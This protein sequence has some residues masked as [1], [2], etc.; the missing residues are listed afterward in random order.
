MASTIRMHTYI[1]FRS[2][3]GLPLATVESPPEL[4]G[5]P[6]A[7]WQIRSLAGPPAVGSTVDRWRAQPT[8]S[9][10]GGPTPDGHGRWPQPAA[11]ATHEEAAQLTQATSGACPPFLAL[12]CVQAPA[13][14]GR[15]SPRGTFD[16]CRST[17]LLPSVDAHVKSAGH[18]AHFFFLCVLCCIEEVKGRGGFC[19]VL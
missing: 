3:T 11:C 9:I 8:F 2:P 7:A 18:A 15:E 4:S 17:S 6:Q 1:R 5:A 12:P 19:V 10:R 14:R 16:A 13:A